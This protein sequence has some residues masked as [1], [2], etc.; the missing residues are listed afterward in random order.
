M[1]T[2]HD[3]LTD[4]TAFGRLPTPIEKKNKWKFS[5]SDNQYILIIFLKVKSDFQF[6]EMLCV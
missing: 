4:T 3:Q 6:I 5:E 1:K 2:A